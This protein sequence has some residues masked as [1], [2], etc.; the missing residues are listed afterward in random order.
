ML[1]IVVLGGVALAIVALI[2]GPRA[3]H[4]RSLKRTLYV[5]GAVAVIYTVLKLTGVIE[6]LAPDRAGVF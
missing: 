6:A 4:P 1:R 3:L 5:L 2:V